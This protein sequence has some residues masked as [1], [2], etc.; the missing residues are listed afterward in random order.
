MSEIAISSAGGVL[1]ILCLVAAFWFY[2]EQMT[3]W[4]L[5]Q[6]LPPLLFIYATPVFLN[7]LNVIPSSSPV[8]SGLSSFALPAFIV[9]MLIKVNVPAAVKIMGKGVL[10]MF[11][12]TA[13]VM[14]GAVV[15]YMIV[16]RWLAPDAWKGF[17][18]L[19]GSWIGG[20]GNM[21][22]ASEMLGTPPEQFGLA[23]LADNV[24]Y[25]V[26]LPILLASRNFATQF[27]RWAKVPEDRLR[28]MDA[29]AN[30]ALEEDRTPE[31]RDYIFL[32]AIAI[33]VT[34]ISSVAAAALYSAMMNSMPSLEVV[35]SESTWRILLIT[36]IAL[37][38][39][40]TP[41]SRL[42]NAT[43]M[44]TALIYIF[45]AGM[46]A[47]ATVE[48]FGQAPAFL[49]GAFIWIFIHG[50]FCVLGAKLFR[51]DVHSVAIASAAN[52]GAAASAPIVAAFH[53]PSLVPV[54]ILMALIGYAMGNYLAPL[55][56]HMARLAVG[57]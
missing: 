50:A 40:V 29:A 20:T 28:L 47:R 49:L 37:L 57:Q 42:P 45:V 39:S 35:L 4:K 16:H 36:T 18:A 41:V 51:V 46:G 48:G 44:G 5:F 33:A 27:N 43:A 8:Y 54:S 23:V 25:I 38:L 3:Q 53:R 11:M 31:M 15:A 7:N 21:A 52:I 14:V 10:V 56:G 6:Y 26:W 32:A 34:W 17:G 22:A 9:L 24:I 55:T 30:V 13:G 1:A 19:A 2:V 12:G